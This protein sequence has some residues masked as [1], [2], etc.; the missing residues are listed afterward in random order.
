MAGQ[1]LKFAVR[2]HQGG[3]S[4]PDLLRVW[5]AADRLGYHG[6]SL[7]DLIAAP[8]LE[9]WTAL[10]A[11]VSAT[12]RLTAIPLVLAQSYRHPALLAK[13]AASL[14][15]IGGGR[16]ILGLG[17]GGSRRD[18]EASG[19]PWHAAPERVA[20]LDET[21]A[22]LR[23]LW[24]GRAET[25]RGR[26]FGAIE[27]PGE[28]RPV[29]PG[30]PPILI[31]GHG[32]RHLLG[33]VARSADFCNIG[34]DLAPDDWRAWQARIDEA[35]HAAGRDPAAIGLTHNATVVIDETPA[36]VE[37]RLAAIARDRGFPP[38]DVRDRLGA[39]II[40]TPDE[41]I[42]RLREY[43]ALG[44]QWVFVLFPDLPDLRSVHLFAE[45]VLP[46]FRA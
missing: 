45:G 9:C 3:W 44:V 39:A 15:V 26:H 35:A 38:A 41:C 21:V 40:G 46:A 1:A 43:A 33:A 25:F 16:V 23:H 22:I 28:P 31:G 14:D 37:E 30:G 13:M 7:Y 8:C 36:R 29:Q 6:G 24:S 5:Q 34:F 42:A 18:Y 4:Y 32:R 17:A 12:E 2:I 19:L 27:G 10:T 20:E 11:L